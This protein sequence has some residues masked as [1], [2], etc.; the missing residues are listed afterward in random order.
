M[1]A[2]EPV[3]REIV[4][5][6]GYIYRPFPV[7]AAIRDHV[8]ADDLGELLLFNGRCRFQHIQPAKPTMS[9]PMSPR[10]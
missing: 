9:S 7:I 4:A 5:A 6:V 10:T 3:S 8:R 2:A 1:V